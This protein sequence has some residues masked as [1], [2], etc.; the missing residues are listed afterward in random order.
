[1]W[2]ATMVADKPHTF[3]ATLKLPA[4]ATRAN[5]AMPS[6]RSIP[7]SCLGKFAKSTD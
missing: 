3:A 2:F 1:M 6:N 4:S 7:H 5:T